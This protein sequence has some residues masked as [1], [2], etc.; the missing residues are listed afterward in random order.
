MHGIVLSFY[1]L[2]ILDENDPDC[3]KKAVRRSIQCG[4]DTDTNAAIVGGIIGAMVGFKA[5]PQDMI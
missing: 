4:G 1:F 5:L 3:Y 2:L